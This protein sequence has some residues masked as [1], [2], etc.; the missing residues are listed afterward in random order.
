[1]TSSGAASGRGQGRRRAQS[2]RQQWA[3]A[4]AIVWVLAAA[5]ALVLAAELGVAR[6]ATFTPEKAFGFYA[7]FGAIASLVIAAGA[8]LWQVIVSRRE[9]YYDD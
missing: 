8:K 9:D 6:H 2:P 7:G 4:W 1:M 3:P 5:G